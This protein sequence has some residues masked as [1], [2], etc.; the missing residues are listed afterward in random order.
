MNG[1]GPRAFSPKTRMTLTGANRC[2]FRLTLAWAFPLCVRC[3]VGLHRIGGTRPQES[4][5]P[6]SAIQVSTDAVSRVIHLPNGRNDQ[7]N[8]LHAGIGCRHLNSVAL[9]GNHSG[10]T[11]PM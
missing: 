5:L 1:T 4:R 3:W 7:L 9:P 8:K 6:V 2:P 11:L 10:D